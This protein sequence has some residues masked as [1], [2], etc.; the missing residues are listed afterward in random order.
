MAA[1]LATDDLYRSIVHDDPPDGLLAA[2]SQLVRRFCGWH[3]APVRVETFVLDGTGGEYL[4]LPTAHL[5][6]VGAISNDGVS[7]DPLDAQWT[8]AG[9]VKTTGRWTTKMRGIVITVTHGFTADEVLDIA[10]QTVLIAARVASS[11]RGEI[12]AAVGGISMQLAPGGLSLTPSE[13][14]TL[15]PYCVA[16]R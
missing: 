13:Q 3:I 5:V 9:V 2:V 10:V 11:P 7:I 14:A 12:N 6:N 8:Q 1:A 4:L 15:L 16:G